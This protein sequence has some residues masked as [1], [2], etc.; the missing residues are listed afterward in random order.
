MINDGGKTISL[1]AATQSR[2]PQLGKAAHPVWALVIILGGIVFS[3]GWSGLL[4]WVLF[5]MLAAS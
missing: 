1:T 4:G 2:A 5:R 3:V